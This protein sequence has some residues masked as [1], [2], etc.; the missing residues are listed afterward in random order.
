MDDIKFEDWRLNV[1]WAAV[2]VA[3]LIA[4]FV[5]GWCWRDRPGS[6]SNVSILNVLTVV[7]TVGA[8]AVALYFGLSGKRQESDTRIERLTSMLWLVDEAVQSAHW[9]ARHL[10]SRAVP[11]KSRVPPE[12]AIHELSA[13]LVSMDAI[14]RIPVHEPHFAEGHRALIHVLGLLRSLTPL[15]ASCRESGDDQRTREQIWGLEEMCSIE[16]DSAKKQEPC[17]SLQPAGR[18]YF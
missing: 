14:N 4:G 9:I 10:R 12:L 18:L 16:L 8:T 2:G 6:L 1:F 17:R 13:F 3:A 7:G 11:L 5:L 15:I